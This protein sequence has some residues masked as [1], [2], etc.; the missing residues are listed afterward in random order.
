MGHVVA[1]GLVWL[2]P[3]EDPQPPPPDINF[4]LPINKD[5]LALAQTGDT[6]RIR[7]AR[8]KERELRVTSENESSRV[9]E[10]NRP[11]YS[12]E[13]AEIQIYRK[14]KYIVA[15]RVGSLPEVVQP[16]TL[17]PGDKLVLT[18]SDIAGANAVKDEE[19]REIEPAHIHC[20]LEAAFAQVQPEARV[21]FDDGK[22]T[23]I[24]KANDGDNI[25]VEITHTR[26]NGAKLRAEKGINFPDTDLHMPALTAKDLADLEQVV[27]CMDMVALSFLR[28]PEDVSLLVDHLYRLGAPHMGIVL[29]IENRQAFEN[30]PKILLTSLRS[31]PVGV[32]VARGDLAV[33][34]GFER[35]SEVQEEILWLC[36]A[37]HVP[38]IWATQM[39]E[40]LAKRGA[41]SRAE[42]TDAAMS[43]R[44]E[45][46]MLN[47]GP[48]IVETVGFL[49][50]V[51]SRM[52]THQY[53]RKAMLRK[54]R[55]SEL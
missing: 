40:G 33:E 25:V 30:L 12:V 9:A 48:N 26:P 47:K 53:K 28:G 11:V 50:G 34:L 22:I 54:L 42:I 46:A 24:T 14:K 43:S 13:D 2:T 3:S 38:V 16:L 49:S 52:D 18:R 55:V 31:P 44:A 39:L 37:A 10:V 27:K 45:C 20:T 32:M 15:G 41:P 35:L 5:S 1:P 7:D 21:F 19:G 8:G 6:I 17:F 23:G 36:E 51:L 29:K 4:V